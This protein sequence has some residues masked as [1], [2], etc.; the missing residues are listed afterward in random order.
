MLSLGV[1]NEE[2]KK[3]LQSF[4]DLRDTLKYQYNADFLKWLID[5]GKANSLTAIP[6]KLRKPGKRRATNIVPATTILLSKK[7]GH[8][9]EFG[10]LVD[11]EGDHLHDLATT[12]TGAR[13]TEER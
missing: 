3:V 11:T 7:D 12:S 13:P 10:K 8:C 2:T 5:L 4:Y 6:T 9:E 1:E